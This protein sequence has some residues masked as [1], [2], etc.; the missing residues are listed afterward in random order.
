MGQ[1]RAC[2]TYPYPFGRVQW[3]HLLQRRRKRRLLSSPMCAIRT[4]T[5]FRQCWSGTPS[6]LS[7]FTIECRRLERLGV[8]VE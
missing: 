5:L 6:L 8:A 7:R 2:S 1:T 3:R 4:V